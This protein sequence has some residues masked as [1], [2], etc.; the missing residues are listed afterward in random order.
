VGTARANQF[1]VAAAGD[2]TVAY[3]KWLTDF[4][5]QKIQPSRFR[6]AKAPT[7][8]VIAPTARALGAFQGPAI[9]F[10]TLAGERPD[11]VLETQQIL[12]HIG[13]LDPPPDGFMGPTTRWAIAEFC[14]LNGLSAT[15]GFTKDIAAALLSPHQLLPEIR[16]SGQWIDRVIAYMQKKN[17]FICRHPDCKNII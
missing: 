12:S 9:S 8:K 5:E 2:V 13:Y 1:V 4:M 10:D 7:A 3:R 15:G 14:K 6:L 16:P 17:Y 11:L